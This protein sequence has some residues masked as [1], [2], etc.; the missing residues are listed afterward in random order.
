MSIFNVYRIK[1]KSQTTIKYMY[2]SAQSKCHAKKIFNAL[3]G[4]LDVIITVDL[5]DEVYGYK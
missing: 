4:L 3:G 5:L 2:I 1:Y